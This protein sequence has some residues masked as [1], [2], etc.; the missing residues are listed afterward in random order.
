M[1]SKFEVG[2]W[3]VT[4]SKSITKVKEVSDGGYGI[5][6]E[7]GRVNNRWNLVNLSKAGFVK[8]ELENS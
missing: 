1:S 2:D 4:K 6:L 5:L 7:T 8:K 3:V